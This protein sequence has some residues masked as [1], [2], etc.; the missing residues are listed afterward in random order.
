LKTAGFEWK[1]ALIALLLFSLSTAAA[2]KPSTAAKPATAN[3][4][5]ASSQIPKIWHSE[6]TQH[7]Y[8][9]ELTK[10]LFRAD[11]VNIPPAAA[12]Q[13]AGIHTE[14]RRTGSKWVGSTSIKMLFAVP[15]APQGKDTKLCSLTMRFE[16]DSVSPEKITGHSEALHLFDVNTCR[17]QE[18][19]WGEFTWIPKK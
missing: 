16:V 8:Q 13:G 4:N 3:S 2:Q 6:T 1:R 9:V 7:D 18:T 12:K 11:W 19:K 10:D 14:C 5:P 17:V 15:G